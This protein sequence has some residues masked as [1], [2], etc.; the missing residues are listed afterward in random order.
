[1]FSKK[2]LTRAHMNELVADTRSTPS[3]RNSFPLFSL[4]LSRNSASEVIQIRDDHVIFLCSNSL[5]R[6]S[7]NR[8]VSAQNLTAHLAT[9]HKENCTISAIRLHQSFSG[10]SDKLFH[11]KTPSRCF[12]VHATLDPTPKRAEATE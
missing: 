12:E 11:R 8:S 2:K 6:P 3:E 9:N 4:L 5:F 1:M 7:N 10:S